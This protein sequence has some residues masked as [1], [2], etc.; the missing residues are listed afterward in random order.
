MSSCEASLGTRRRS[1]YQNKYGRTPLHWAAYGGRF[2]V[3]KLLLEH[4]ADPNT[5]DEDGRTPL[6]KAAYKGHVDVVKLFLE[7]GVDPN[8][9]DKDGGRR[10]T[11]RRLGPCRCC[12]ASSGTRRDPNIKN[13]YGE[14]PLHKAAFGGRVDVVKLLLEH[15]VDPNTQDKYG[16]TPLHEAAYGAM[17]TL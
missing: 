1:K 16:R 13:K 4:G 17:S 5:Q 12:E 2:D 14:T 10:C 15:G 3:V 7:L 9:Q 8:T 6:H 11:R